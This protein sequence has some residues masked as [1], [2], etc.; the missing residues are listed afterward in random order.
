[1]SSSWITIIVQALIFLAS[2]GYL[3]PRIVDRRKVTGL[4]SDLA[5]KVTEYQ[6]ATHQIDELKARVSSLEN[7]LEAVVTDGLNKD[8]AIA[9]ILRKNAIL[10]ATIKRYDTARATCQHQDCP[11]ERRHRR[12]RIVKGSTP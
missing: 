7:R 8:T 12:T 1:M 2:A 5:A 10:E 3:G 11:I 4:Q 9:S 6:D